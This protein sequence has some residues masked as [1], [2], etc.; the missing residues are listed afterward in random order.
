MYAASNTEKTIINQKWGKIYVNTLIGYCIHLPRSKINKKKIIKDVHDNML[1][2]IYLI[3]TCQTLNSTENKTILKCT[4]NSLPQYMQRKPI[5]FPQNKFISCANT[6]NSK[7]N[8][9]LLNTILKFLRG[10]KDQKC[11]ILWK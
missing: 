2:K 6:R 4:E 3:N 1:N 8:K 5:N 7:P 10:E 9:L 11:K